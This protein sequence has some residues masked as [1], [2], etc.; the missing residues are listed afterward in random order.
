[1]SGII[2]SII[3]LQMKVEILSG[4]WEESEI[5]MT[6]YLAGRR[7]KASSRHCRMCIMESKTRFQNRIAVSELDDCHELVLIAVDH[8]RSIVKNNGVAC[9]DV[10]MNCL[11]DL[12]DIRLGSSVFLIR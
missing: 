11:I 12:I 9:G 10:V 6:K 7:Q 1:M 5:Y 8:F 3:V 2:L 4:L